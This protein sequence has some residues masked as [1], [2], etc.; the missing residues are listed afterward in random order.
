LKKIASGQH[1]FF[2]ASQALSAGYKDSNYGYHIRKG[3]WLKISTGLFRLPGYENSMEADLTRWS[4]WSRNQSDQPQA[5]IS[6]RTAM[7]YHGLMDYNS[8]DI[9]MTVPFRFRKLFPDGVSLHRAQL[10]L[11]AIECNDCFM[12]T[13]LE[14]TLSDMREELVNNHQWEDI[15]RVVS[16]S[17]RL[18]DAELR[19]LGI[20]VVNK[21]SWFGS[22]SGN[23]KKVDPI[24][25]GA[26]Q[27]IYNRSERA[28]AKAAGFTLVELLVVI[29]I[30][31]ILASMLTPYM[32]SAQQQAKSISCINNLKSIG[33]FQQMYANEYSGWGPKPAGNL[34][35]SGGAGKWQDL[36]IVY[37]QPGIILSDLCYCE[38][39]STFE[40]KPR[41]IFFCPTETEKWYNP[42]AAGK[43]Y[44][45]NGWI[46]GYGSRPWRIYRKV[47]VPSKCVSVGD[48]YRLA[49]EGTLIA[50]DRMADAGMANYV[51]YYHNAQTANF[52]FLDAHTST[53]TMLKVP[54]DYDNNDFWHSMT[55]Y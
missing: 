29:S 18:T 44:S 32:I 48:G 9:H 22:S 26:W 30:I 33:F 5:I 12:V 53:L 3:S 52:V 19:E 40:F 54:Y 15:V 28:R 10:S 50:G 7:A 13:R 24:S 17:D 37:S 16:A 35:V 27:M 45:I 46:A 31:A 55:S 6:H 34:V 47:R 36:L 49:A 38:R 8:N 42:W 20:T 2:T 11:S 1:G 4:L 14:Q 21:K 23:I 25:E 39:R 41:G 51:Q 43:H